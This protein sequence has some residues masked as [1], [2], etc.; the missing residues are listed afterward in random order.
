MTNSGMEIKSQATIPHSKIPSDIKVNSFFLTCIRTPFNALNDIHRYK[1]VLNGMRN[2]PVR[3]KEMKHKS[4]VNYIG[5]TFVFRFL[6]FRAG[7]AL[8]VP[9]ARHREQ[10]DKDAILSLY[11]GI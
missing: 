2:I 1:G 5:S 7:K 10:Y 3:K 6:N 11:A 8:R 4:A 9:Q